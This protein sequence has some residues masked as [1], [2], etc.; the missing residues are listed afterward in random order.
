VLKPEGRLV[1]FWPPEF[2][3]SVMGLKAVVQVANCFRK[4]PLVLHPDEISRIQSF[5]WLRSLMARNRFRVLEAR[6]SWRDLF[7]YVVVVGQPV[8][9]AEGS[10]RRRRVAPQEAAA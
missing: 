9:A 7:T 2:G 5:A 6:F 1:L 4:T 8:K 3:A 10:G